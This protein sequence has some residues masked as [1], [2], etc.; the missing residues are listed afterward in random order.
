MDPLLYKGLVSHVSREYS[1]FRTL[2]FIDYCLDML[3]E[4]CLRV[5]WNQRHKRCET[6]WS[7]YLGC[8]L[9]QAQISMDGWRC[10]ENKQSKSLIGN[11]LSPRASLLT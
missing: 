6:P 5:E 7:I 9:V 11:Y 2:G 8:G 1:C 4:S 3:G 10:S